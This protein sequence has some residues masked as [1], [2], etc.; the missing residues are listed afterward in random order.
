M[1]KYERVS[2]YVLMWETGVFELVHWLNGRYSVCIQKDTEERWIG[3]DE[4]KDK[5]TML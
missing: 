4:K 5:S 2:T 3:G 1:N